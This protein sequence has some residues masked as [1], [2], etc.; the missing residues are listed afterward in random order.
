MP[1]SKPKRILNKTEIAI[2]RVLLHERRPLTISEISRKANIS[3]VTAKKYVE[4][5]LDYGVVEWYEE[6]KGDR[7]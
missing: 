6:I 4:R 1:R 2:A 7:K 3:W 5:L